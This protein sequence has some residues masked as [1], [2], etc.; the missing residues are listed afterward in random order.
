M[1]ELHLCP[2]TCDSLGEP[3]PWE[4]KGQRTLKVSS[5]RIPFWKDPL[6]SKYCRSLYVTV[7]CMP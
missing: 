6:C 5:A 2:V 4:E 3:V 7:N 1:P